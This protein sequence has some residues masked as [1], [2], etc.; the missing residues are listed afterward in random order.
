MVSVES[1]MA[2]AAKDWPASIEART[3]VAVA[4]V[5][6]WMALRQIVR[7]WFVCRAK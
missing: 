6:V 7:N 1:A 2:A 3:C 4:S 5:A